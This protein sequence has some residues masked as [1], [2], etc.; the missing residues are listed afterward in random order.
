VETGSGK[1]TA[2]QQKFVD[3]LLSDPQMN[4][5]LAYIKAYPRSDSESAARSGPRLLKNADVLFALNQA[6]SERAKRVEVD[7]DFVI[8]ALVKESTREG[9]DTSHSARVSALGLLGKHLGMFAD[10]LK[11]E[12][13][14]DPIVT[15]VIVRTREEASA[16]AKLNENSNSAN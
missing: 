8:Q 12:H 11:V 5:T 15:E 6:R 3:N 4:A 14:G 7:Q 9:K 13:V 16:L 10:K 2:G 1:L